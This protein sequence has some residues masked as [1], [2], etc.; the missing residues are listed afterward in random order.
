MTGPRC[1]CEPGDTRCAAE[2]C[3]GARAGSDPR[4]RVTPAEAE[5]HP[6]A[7]ASDLAMARAD[8]A[9]AAT[10]IDTPAGLARFRLLQQRGALRIEIATGM[11]HSGG[12]VLALVNREQGT[13]FRTKQAAA[14]YLTWLLE[15]P[16]E[17]PA[18]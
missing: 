11:R 12:S 10:V 13:R 2:G 9:R 8:R 16:H 3:R 7:D 14:D 5:A 6:E 1:T 17:L 15:G 18:D 4:D